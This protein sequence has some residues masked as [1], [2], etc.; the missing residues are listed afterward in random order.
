MNNYKKYHAIETRKTNLKN[1]EMKKCS[2]KKTLLLTKKG[3]QVYIP[4]HLLNYL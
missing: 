1:K 2:P 3:E 4:V